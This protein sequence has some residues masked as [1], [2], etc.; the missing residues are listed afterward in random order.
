MNIMNI[1]NT[2][3][4]N[5]NNSENTLPSRVTLDNFFK[6]SYKKLKLI[7]IIDKRLELY[8]FKSSLLNNLNYDSNKN[9]FYY[10][11]IHNLNIL[12]INANGLGDVKQIITLNNLIYKYDIIFISESWFIDH[13][14][15]INEPYFVSSTPLKLKKGFRQID[16]IY[17]FA[18]PLMKKMIKVLYLTKYS[19]TIKVM[20]KI[21]KAIYYPPSLNNEKFDNEFNDLFKPDLVL[22]DFNIN[23]YKQYPLKKHNILN[24]YCSS[25]SLYPLIPIKK[26]NICLPRLDHVFAKE[27]L[28][29]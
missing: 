8:E 19:I 4:F 26:S 13:E 1:F 28:K 17:C 11:E 27:D 15:I 16:G 21:I 14:K 10:N 6:L 20:G 7:H 22:G 24:K 23:I 2:N 5:N 9:I 12:Y 25:R 3:T 29:R 18:N